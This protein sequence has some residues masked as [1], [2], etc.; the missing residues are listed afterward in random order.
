MRV[1][2]ELTGKDL[3]LETLYFVVF[4]SAEAALSSRAREK[5]DASRAVI[6]RAVRSEAAVYGVNTGFGKM[7]STR[8]SRDEIRARIRSWR[9][10]TMAISS[11]NR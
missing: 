2:V 5:V 4:D 10:T 11:S 1:T 6:E 9:S 8:I 7:A 3:T